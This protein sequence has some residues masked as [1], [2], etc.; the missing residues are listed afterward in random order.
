M[1]ISVHKVVRTVCNGPNGSSVD[2]AKTQ[3]NRTTTKFTR[4]DADGN[5]SSGTLVTNLK[6][7]GEDEYLVKSVSSAN[8]NTQ[9]YEYTY[10]KEGHVEPKGRIFVGK[11]W[12]SRYVQRTPGANGAEEMNVDSRYQHE[13]VAMGQTVRLS[14]GKTAKSVVKVATRCLLPTGE[15]S[16]PTYNYYD[17]KISGWKLVRS[18]Y[19]NGLICDTFYR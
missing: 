17:R 2:V 5:T 18:D 6:R 15:F 14:N 19:T 1:G 4:T 7:I 3:G 11:T 9:D 16:G 13:I 8:G 12:K 10:K